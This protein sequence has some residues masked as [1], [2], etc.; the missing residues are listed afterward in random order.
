MQ[1]EGDDADSAGGA[2]AVDAPT[3]PAYRP[4]SPAYRPTSPPVFWDDYEEHVADRRRPSP[5]PRPSQRR[6]VD[7]E[8][9]LR[10]LRLRF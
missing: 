10:D 1:G 4:T 9:P 5:N 7:G 6:R 8:D 3:S 2:A